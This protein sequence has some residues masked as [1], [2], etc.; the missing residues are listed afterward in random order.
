M[1]AH[2]LVFL[3]HADFE[4]VADGL[5]DGFGRDAVFFIVGVLNG[6]AALGLHDGALHAGRDL[7]CVHEH[8]AVGVAGRAADRL[9][10]ACLA[11]QEAFLIGIQNRN[12]RYL[13]QIQTLAQQ[14]DANNNIN[15]ADA[16]VLDDL[17]ALKG[18]HLVVHILDL[19]ALFGKVV[20]QVFGH[21]LSQGG[22]KNALMPLDAGVDLTQQIHHLPFHRAHRDDRVQ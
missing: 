22:H 14:V 7:I 19:D 13:R 16:Q 4:P 12:Q 8:N 20:G 11:A 9:N 21:F 18:I 6:A 1:L 10:Q 17:H 5:D 3:A 15:C 2:P